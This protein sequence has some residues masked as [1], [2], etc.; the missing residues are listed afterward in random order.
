MTERTP[1]GV[2]GW[3]LVLCLLLLVWQPLS[4]GLVASTTLGRLPLRGLPFAMTL[5]GRLFAAAI[6]IAAGLSIVARRPAALALARGALIASAAMDAFIYSTPY[7][8]NNRPPQ[9]TTIALVA[10]VAY[11]TI[12]LVYLAR[13]KRV[14]NTL[15]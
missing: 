15:G 4:L 2:G 10:S 1:A 7:V 6:G 12:W 13:S 3:L 5:L 9:D 14:R 11:S 8:P